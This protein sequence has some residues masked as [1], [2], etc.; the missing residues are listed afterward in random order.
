MNNQWL[1]N[2][3]IELRSPE[4][5][6]LEL[7]YKMENDT[8]LWSIGCSTLPYSRHTLRAYLEQSTQNLYAEGQARFIITLHSG[9]S[10]GMIDLANFDPHNSRAEV[11]IG[12]LDNYRQ[13]GIASEALSLLTTYSLDFLHLH[14]LYAYVPSDNEASLQLFRKA[15]FEVTAELKDWISNDALYKNVFLVQM[16]RK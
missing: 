16:I 10:V 5:E 2:E 12:I 6:D 3:R 7:L 15:G 14:Q 11:C 1:R 8:R 9:E 13:Q 4:P